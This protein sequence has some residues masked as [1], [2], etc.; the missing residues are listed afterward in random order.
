MRRLIAIDCSGDT[1]IATLDE[2]SA[3]TGLLIVSGGNEIRC[4]AHRGMALLATVIAGAGVPVLRYDRRGIGDSTGMNGGFL[5]AQEDL[6]AAAAAFRREMPQVARIVA[7][8]N[9]DAATTLALFGR[10]AGV[11][12]V[13][14]ANPWI[15]EDDDG[16]PPRA[17]IRARYLDRLRRPPATLI[18]GGVDLRKLLNGLRKLLT[19][20]DQH[21]LADRVFAALADWGPQARLLV[22]AGDA[23]ALAFLD[24]TR[25][26]QLT[27]NRIETDSHSFAREADA[28]ALQDWIMAG[29]TPEEP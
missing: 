20:R 22:A 27:I 8:G 25:P 10:Q 12:R 18:A 4:G 16:M 3:R 11:D 28:A 5:S 29:L 19:T 17:A 15:V 21:G 24:A 7:F 9:C 2:A 6:A 14:L 13:L 23:T 1:L 26:M